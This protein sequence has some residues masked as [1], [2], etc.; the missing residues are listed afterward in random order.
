MPARTKKTPIILVYD[1]T[2][3]GRFAV[4]DNGSLVFEASNENANYGD[5]VLF[6]DK[7]NIPCE[8]RDMPEGLGGEAFPLLVAALKD[9]ASVSILIDTKDEAE[10]LSIETDDTDLGWVSKT[11]AIAIRDRLV[12]ALGKC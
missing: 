3:D 12:E 6:C 5:F 2:D 10:Y 9:K 7:F 1:S 8:A 4:Y 11:D